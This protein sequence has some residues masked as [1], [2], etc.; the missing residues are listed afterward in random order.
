MFS[1][2]NVCK[3]SYAHYFFYSCYLRIIFFTFETKLLVS[4]LLFIKARILL[5]EYNTEV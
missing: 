4:L 1:E 2:K 5:T 3:F